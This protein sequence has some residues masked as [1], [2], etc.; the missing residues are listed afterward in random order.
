MTRR[1]MLVFLGAA[2]LGCSNQRSINKQSDLPPQIDDLIAP[3]ELNISKSKLDTLLGKQEENE[4]V[5]VSP[6]RLAPGRKMVTCRGVKVNVAFDS[7][8]RVFYLAS[9]DER[10]R[11]KSGCG[12]GQSFAEVKARTPSPRVFHFAGYGTMISAGSDCWLVFEPGSDELKDDAIVT[13][14]EYRNDMD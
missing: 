3:L 5:L 8:D 13:W 12:P 2:I 10:L 6:S 7:N 14:I 9:Q 4:L 1:S 11:S